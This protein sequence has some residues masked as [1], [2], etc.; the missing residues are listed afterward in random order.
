ME[1]CAMSAS[2][3]VSIRIY[4]AENK[5]GTMTYERTVPRY[6]LV[7]LTVLIL[8]LIAP[9]SA[10]GAG[11]RVVQPGETI[12]VGSEPLVLDLVNLRNPDTFNPVTDLRRYKDDNRAKK[13]ERVIGVPNDG[14]FKISDQALGGKYGRYFAYSEKDGLLEHSIIFSPAPAA[15]PTPIE[16]ATVTEAPT[17]TGT[18]GATTE[19]TPTQTRAPLPGLIA[20][21][22]IG[23]C[24][25]F[26]A[27][28]RR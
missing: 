9:V 21:A 25:L 11:P 12:E 6:L 19:A 26:L 5:G 3:G 18:P 1:I 27:A 2:G 20:V 13:I 10:E 28:G 4:V 14:Y 15:T 23:L 7:C 22:A 8:A 24:G 16:T 17:E